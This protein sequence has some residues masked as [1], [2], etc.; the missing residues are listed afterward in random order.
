ML[1]DL[2]NTVMPRVSPYAIAG[3]DIVMM[4]AALTAGSFVGLSDRGDDEG[5]PAPWRHVMLVT[6]GLT[7]ATA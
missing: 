1:V 6:A 7:W 5:D 2:I 3:L 4:A